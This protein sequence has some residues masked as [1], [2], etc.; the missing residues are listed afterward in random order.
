MTEHFDKIDKAAN[1]N[2]PTLKGCWVSV[3]E[4]QLPKWLRDELFTL[5]GKAPYY[6]IGTRTVT[7]QPES[8]E[9]IVADQVPL[10]LQ[11]G[12]NASLAIKLLPVKYLKRRASPLSI[13]E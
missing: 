1:D 5:L 10:Y 2:D 4:D 11:Q 13:T 12:V 7:G 6:V 3:D 8:A 9:L